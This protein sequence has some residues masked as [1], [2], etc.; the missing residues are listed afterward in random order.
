M[1]F[2]HKRDDVNIIGLDRGERNLI[3]LSMINTNGEIVEGMQFSL[4]KL[5]SVEEEKG[6][7]SI[8]TNY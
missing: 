4:N 3:Y 2:L 6:K 8:I 5:S 1:E 7:K